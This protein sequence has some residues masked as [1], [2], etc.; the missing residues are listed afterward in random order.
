MGPD[1]RT[2]VE[3]ACRTVG[4]VGVDMGTQEI[5][6]VCEYVGQVDV[7]VTESDGFVAEY[8]GSL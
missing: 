6:R 1:D 8:P 2:K 7:D 4:C 5:R 3:L